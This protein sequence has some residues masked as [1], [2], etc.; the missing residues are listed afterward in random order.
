VIVIVDYGMGNLGSIFNMLRKI[1]APAKV[2]SSV[3]DILD[4]ERLILPGVGAFDSGMRNLERLGF[5]HALEERV[6]KGNVPFLGLC[7]GMQLLTRRG[8]EGVLPGLG[9]IAGDTV[10]FRFE[11]ERDRLKVPHM[12][13]NTVR[14]HPRGALSRGFE[15]QGRLYFVQY[16]HLVCDQEENVQ[17]WTH[18]GFDFAS[19]IQSGNILGV[20]FHPEKSHKYG[21]R[22]LRNFVEMGSPC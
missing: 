10:R 21:L 1:G 11:G 14:F 4:A 9:W 15:G 17:G 5:R 22:L 12:G 20:Q 7:L 19:Y 16:Y 18:H 6:L 2:S 8:E 3:G 13:W